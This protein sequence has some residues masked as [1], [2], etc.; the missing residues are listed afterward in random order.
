M[1]T[2][3]DNRL[4][5][6][7]LE[8]LDSMWVERKEQWAMHPSAISFR[9]RIIE[10]SGGWEEKSDQVGDVEMAIGKCRYRL[11]SSEEVGE[12]YGVRVGSYH[13]LC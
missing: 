2:G 9:C 13:I 8:G 7:L 6:P 4:S 12:L 1:K 3:R 11:S 5:S 10:L